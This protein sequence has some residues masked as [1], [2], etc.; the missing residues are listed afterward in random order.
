MTIYLS[1]QLV[2]R[3]EELAKKEGR[4][5]DGLVEEAVRRYVEAAAITDVSPE[6]IA[7]TQ[8]KLASEFTDSPW[9]S[10]HTS[11]DF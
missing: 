6:G 1:D 10:T 3:L 7:E 5:I 11:A 4:G 8:E 9:N 2:S